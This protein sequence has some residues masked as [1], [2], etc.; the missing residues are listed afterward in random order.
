VAELEWDSVLCNAASFAGAAAYDDGDVLWCTTPLA[1]L[2][3]LGAGVLGGLLSGATVLLGKGML[4]R[5]ELAEL[6]GAEE[7]T[8]L[9]SVPFLFR[10]YLETL[11]GEPGIAKGWRLRC[12]IAAGEAVPPE[13]IA[14][15]RQAA[16]VELRSHYGLTEGGQITLAAGGESEGVG[17]PLDDVELQIEEGGEVSVR[18]RPPACPYRVIGS[19]PHPGGWY[20]TGDLG[21]L[22]DDGNLHIS[23]RADS[24]INVAGK[25]IDPVEV[26][27]ALSACA[28]VEDCAV[29]SIEGPRGTEVVAFMRVA[30]EDAAGDA[31]IRSQLAERLSPHKLPRRFVRVVEI[32]RTLTGKVRR[33][34]L[35]AGLS[36]PSPPRGAADVSMLDLICREAAAVVL[37]NASAEAIEPERAFKELGFDSIAAV[38]LAESLARATGLEVAATA[39]FDHPTPVA[40]AVH[41]GALRDGE[42]RVSPASRWGGSR[43]LAEPIAIVGMSCRFPGGVDSPA[44]LWD[45]VDSGG[46]AISPFPEDRG[47]DLDRL[48]HPDPDHPGTSYAREGGFLTGAGEFD[49]E[50]FGISPR[51]ALAMDPQQRL[52]LEASW[53]ALEDA[54]IDPATLRGTPAG[55]FAGVMQQDYAAGSLP[56]SAEGYLTTGLAESVVSGRVAYSLGL[57]GPAVTVNTAC[58]SSLVAMHLG[59]QALRLDE[60]SLALAGGV[61]V[62]ATPAQFVE[63]SRQRGLAPDGRCKPFAAG[64]DGTGWSEGVG[65]VV[66]ERL[67]DARRLGHRV[68]ATVR[69]S[70]INQD[71]ASNGLTA[72]NGPSQERVIRRALANAGLEPEEVD[73]VEAHGTGTPLG[74]PIEARALLATYGQGRERALRLGSVKSNLGHTLAAAG[75]AGVIKMV[76]ALR[77]GVLP[78]TLHVDEPTPQVDW[79]DAVELL[80]EAEPWDAGDRPRRAG[81]SSFGISGTNAHL[82]L[83]EGTEE[84]DVDEAGQE[85]PPLG[86]LLPWL[87]SAKGEDA[88]RGQATRL[89]DRLTD[90]PDLGPRDVAFT[91][92]TCRSQHECRAVVLG[93]DREEL[94]GGLGA[95][96]AGRED[97]AVV[98]APTPARGEH[99]PVFLF[100]GQGSQW[101][102]MGRELFERS[103]EFAAEIERCELALSPFVEWSLT[104]V[105]RDR[106]GA[107]LDRL[108]VVQPALFATMVSL[109][110]LWQR[111]RVRPSIVVGHSQGEIAAAHIAGGLSLEDA[112]RVVALRGKAMAQI[113]GRG[114]MLSVSLAPAEVPPLLEPLGE[115]V[116]LA[117]INGPASLVLSGDPGA[118]VDLEE[119]CGERGI[120][121]QRIAVDYAAH[122][123]QIE[124]LREELLDA[125]APISPRSGE[126]PFYSTVTGGPLDTAELAADYWYRNLR[127]TVLLEPVLRSLLEQGRRTFLEVSPHPV[128]GFGLQE[129]I[130]AA[131]AEAAVGLGTLRRGDGGPERFMR[132]L[133]EAHVHGIDVDWG[134]RFEG[135]SASRVD[136]PTYAF[137][138]KRY[139]IES[140][141]GVGNLSAVGMATVEHPLL[142]ASVSVAGEGE[143]RLFAGRLSLAAQ[144]WLADHAVFGTAIV[145]GTAFLELALSV[146][147]EVGA[148]AVEELVQEAPLVLAESASVQVQLIAEDP[149]EE[150]R[151]GFSIYSRAEGSEREWV[152]NA[153]GVLTPPARVLS[154]QQPPPSWPPAGAEPLDTELFYDRLAERG[155]DYGP[156]FQGLRSA[157][158]RD[159]EIYAEVELGGG[160]D[161]AEGFDIDPCLFDAALHAS[162]L[163]APDDV[164]LP[165]SW[166]GVILHG[167]ATGALRVR[168]GATAGGFVVHIANADGSPVISIESLTLRPLREGEL[169]AA[170][171]AGLDALHRLEWRELSS[172]CDGDGAALDSPEVLR[173]DP[174][175]GTEVVIAARAA[176][177]WA[178]EL[179][180]RLLASERGASRLALV[181]RGAMAAV[182]GEVPD[183]AG[184]SLW[185]LLRSAQAEH[186][187]RFT[188]VDVDGSQASEEALEAALGLEGEPQLAIRA[189]RV[190]VP[191]LGR[192]DLDGA[193][194]ARP[195]DPEATVLITGGTGTLGALAARHLVEAR[196]A[197]HLLLLSRSGPDAAGIGKLKGELEELGAKV[198]VI[199][200]DVAKRDELAAVLEGIPEQHPLG[201]VIH[202]AGTLDDGVIEALTPERL[203][204][205]FAPKVDAAWNL[206]ELTE[207]LELSEFVLFSSIAATFGSLGQANYAAAN[208]FLDALATLGRADGRRTTAIA[209]GLWARASALTGHLDETDRSRLRRSG[210]APIED[211]HGLE[212][213]DMASGLDRAQLIAAPLESAALRAQ[214]RS[215]TLPPIFRELIRAPGGQAVGRGSWTAQ[216]ATAPGPERDALARALVR[217]EV[218]TVLGHTAP[219]AVDPEQ[220]FNELGFD[221]L[222][223][224]ELRNRLSTLTGLRL[225]ATLIFDSPSTNAVVQFLLEAM[226]QNSAAGSLLKTHMDQLEA[227]FV[228]AGTDEM[229]QLIPRLSS[230]LAR[231]SLDSDT[232]GLA[233]EYGDLESASDDDVIKLIDDEFGAA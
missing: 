191:R 27:E 97:G 41:L 196:G 181:T 114:G 98:S 224:V 35:I 134:A 7:P 188:L 96:A 155:F 193:G 108:D 212:L 51:E 21:R 200:C 141:A 76:E 207:G 94:L 157:W 180:Q 11:R 104:E 208:A 44:A 55:V 68:L 198:Q 101:A 226:D 112:A 220:A 195:F 52:L 123:A 43:F 139:W 185:G 113:A 233:S 216:L 30:E 48:Y 47:W 136:L 106:D 187:G 197:R 166:S 140:G 2:Y 92:A 138:R 28:G 162:L 167:A 86:S 69:G 128:L 61:T 120:R 119:A 20:R 59:C 105:L 66:L 148:S 149:D 33:G 15:W 110:R 74:D 205:V 14:A 227:S 17:R 81:V 54:G 84:Q 228:S 46:E 3:C 164:Q 102:G 75:V 115:R 206:Y 186:P 107:W 26:E 130:D 100:P 177:E 225:P 117:A 79:A 9:L 8:V 70:A 60:C 150:G 192:V 203:E 93:R 122:S 173:W 159:D 153:S 169:R 223:A 45:L 77:R 116:S 39:V 214:A 199:A 126:V 161:R 36:A 56:E 172:A 189:G 232:V 176:A 18:R 147:R 34:A 144:P 230:L 71:G 12:A 121:A 165:F 87:V 209:W 171:A 32:P 38:S 127:Q 6:V 40:L 125:F 5:G 80:R 13:L 62:M 215:G 145:P 137:H 57:E 160:G 4:E 175:S 194:E 219:S 29:A 23:G 146:G 88:M 211:E 221:S 231:A 210:T 50:F 89:L 229:M 217:T 202:A 22:D 109:A 170:A 91:L 53:E 179:L 142:G 67:A 135:S 156:G 37:G 129:T 85:E 19:E 152:R 31:A 163:A 218:A 168:L 25:K 103:P 72:P 111:M 154:P 124:E 178:L 65:L 143:R 95:I 190:L 42:E 131:A 99:R 213:L 182:D 222:T 49:A 10:R 201:A 73:A 204:A 82:I 63:F 158:R 83:E 151:L 132:A 174:E 16:G 183:L 184:A 64:A 1:H 90:Q 24:R 58:S 133:A 118:L 78:Q